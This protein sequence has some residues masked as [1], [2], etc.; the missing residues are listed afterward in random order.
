MARNGEKG[1]KD[2]AEKMVIRSRW[3]N[4]MVYGYHR[5]NERPLRRSGSS[6]ADDG[7]DLEDL[8]KR[9]TRHTEQYLKAKPG[10]R[11]RCQIK[12]MLCFEELC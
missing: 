5:C 1:W 6:L 9:P 11:Y 3:N 7:I 12:K 8:G 10:K 2:R 4:G